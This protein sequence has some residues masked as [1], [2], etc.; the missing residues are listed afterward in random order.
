MGT[1]VVLFVAVVGGFCGMAYMAHLD[2]KRAAATIQWPRQ[3]TLEPHV[4]ATVVYG[5][6]ITL[7]NGDRIH[8]A[9]L[10]VCYPGE[11]RDRSGQLA[12]EANKLLVEG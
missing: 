5:G 2:R 3:A 11:T 4:C 12:Y 7:K 1:R 8:Y 10:Q 6:A 9:D